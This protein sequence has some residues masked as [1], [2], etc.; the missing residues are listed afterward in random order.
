[1]DLE[2]DQSRMGDFWIWEAFDPDS[3]A[4]PAFH[5]GKRESAD[6]NAFVADVAARMRNR[7]QVSADGLAL[8]V[9]AIERA[10]GGAVDF[11][12]IVKTYEGEPIGAGRYAP[13]RVSEVT[14]RP[15]VGNP[16]PAKIS[17]SG[18]ERVNLHNRMRCR[19]LTRLVDSFSRKVENLQAALR[20]HFAVYNYAKRHRSLGG[21]T[22]A[23]ALG[24]SDTLWSVEDLVGLAG[25]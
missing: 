25:W 13:P 20:V 15:L 3:K 23:M 24:V 21:A 1:M 22:P 19:R 8:Y 11:A 14:K 4:V 17:T 16:D 18:V 5:L 2:D 9:E 7:V 6:A 10:F 12:Q